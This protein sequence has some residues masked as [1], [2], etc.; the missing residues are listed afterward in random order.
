MYRQVQYF[1]LDVFKSE[2]L[3][4]RVFTERNLKW[5]NKSELYLELI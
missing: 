2:N 5:K 1:Y 3:L 4:S